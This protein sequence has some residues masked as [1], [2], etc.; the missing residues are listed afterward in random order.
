[1]EQT[2][3][4]IRNI[5]LR[6]FVLI[7]SLAVLSACTSPAPAQNAA[8]LT[9]VVPLTPTATN[10][11]QTILINT[12]WGP[13]A[14]LDGLHALERVYQKENP[15][16]D[17]NDNPSGGGGGGTDEYLIQRLRQEQP[18]DSMVIHA[19]KESLDY[20]LRGQL[21]PITKLFHEEGFDKV[22][23]LLL[24][25]QISIRGEIYSMPID[26]HRSNLIWYNPKV[27]KANNLQ[28]PRTMEEF[29]SVAEK[30]K[31]K[32]I[33]PLAIGGGFELGQL[34]E[35]VLLATY[36]P[37]DY[38]RLLN[39]DATLWEDE[40]LTSAIK[41]FKRMLDYTNADRSATGWDVAAVMVAS[42]KAAMTETGDWANGEYKSQGAKPNI[43]YGWAPAPSTDGTFMWLSD[44]FA[45]PKGSSHHD[46][47]LAWLKAVG[48]KEGQDAFNPIKGAIPA[49]TDPDKTLYDEY[50]QWSIDQ[51][52]TNK[53]APSIVHGAAAS[54]A[55]R[56]Q[57][58]R[59]VIDFS[60]NGDEQTFK[61][62]LREAA[63]QL[64]Q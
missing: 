46:A 19:G 6:G 21:E 15:N 32:G 43:D 12:V 40:R 60:Q 50:Q 17:I 16:I 25:Q 13:G 9:S 51:F 42:G 22:M 41:T 31:A 62:T 38:V 47:V 20:I 54:D 63:T 2:V 56:E 37:D 24:L 48:S 5:R 23:P 29:F 7:F 4:F 49:R 61:E 18:P 39:G 3:V 33:T 1:M 11:R 44:S 59:A 30:F 10:G 58:A 36:G 14:E 55:Y 28:P 35:S 53:L 8:P 26:I 52:R 34:F 27:F 57:Y 64:T 45:L